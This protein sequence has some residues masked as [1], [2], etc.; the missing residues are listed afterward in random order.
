MSDLSKLLPS[1]MRREGAVF[2]HRGVSAPLRHRLTQHTFAA[3]LKARGGREA[4]KMS[5]ARLE[6][7][8]VMGSHYIQNYTISKTKH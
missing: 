5:G 4:W 7:K 6:R 3:T 8:L 2:L 1:T